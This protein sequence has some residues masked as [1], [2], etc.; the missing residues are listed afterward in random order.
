MPITITANN[1]YKIKQMIVKKAQ[2][3]NASLGNGDRNLIMPE[4]KITAR[5]KQSPSS[6][7]RIVNGDGLNRSKK[8]S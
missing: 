8:I 4:R 6:T 7:Q 3:P 1:G 2:N 5:K